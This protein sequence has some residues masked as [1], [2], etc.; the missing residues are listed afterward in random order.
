MISPGLIHASVKRD[1]SFESED[2]WAFSVP[3][4]VTMSI[5]RTSAWWNDPIAPAFPLIVA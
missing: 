5:P 4:R 1:T 3:L 2:V